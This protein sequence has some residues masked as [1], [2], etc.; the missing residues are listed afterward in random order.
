MKYTAILLVQRKKA[1]EE[2]DAY[3]ANFIEQRNKMVRQHQNDLEELRKVHET[4]IESLA[5]TTKFASSAAKTA[6][7]SSQ[8]KAL[9]VTHPVTHP[10]T[11]PA[12]PPLN[13]KRQ[14]EPELV[15]HNLLEENSMPLLEGRRWSSINN[16]NININVNNITLLKPRPAKI[17]KM[18]RRCSV[19]DSQRPSKAP[20][21]KT[22]LG[23]AVKIPDDSNID[24]EDVDSSGH[25]SSFLVPS[26]KETYELY[27]VKTDDRIVTDDINIGEDNYLN[28]DSRSL[29]VRSDK[30][31]AKWEKK[32]QLL[33]E[34]KKKHKTMK[35]PR[36]HNSKLGHWINNQRTS[37][38][39]EKLSEYYVQRLN[40]IGFVWQVQISI[41]WTTMYNRLLSYRDRHDGS[42]NVSSIEYS[43]LRSWVRT[44]RQTHRQGKL[45]NERV[46]LLESIGFQWQLEDKNPLMDIDGNVQTSYRIQNVKC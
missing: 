35:V 31:H 5:A 33:V 7:S 30:Y 11:P 15:D 45:V 22:N 19:S 43:R 44:Q 46:I 20:L 40:S 29:V 27:N 24:K 42:T 1:A 10:V 39:W 23:A 34:Y 32:F 2:K 25:S 26:N 17:R 14:M 28:G 8:T 4:K 36:S 37:Y 18:D 6:S 12:T 38:R 16:N 9:P 3:V 41:P 13:R 21:S